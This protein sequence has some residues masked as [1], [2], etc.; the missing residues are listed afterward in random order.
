M[1]HNTRV[2]KPEK[3]IP[4]EKV[5]RALET[6]LTAIKNKQEPHYKNMAA[7][8]NANIDA[9]RFTLLKT[10]FAKLLPTLR[11]SGQNDGPGPITYLAERWGLVRYLPTRDDAAKFLIHVGGRNHAL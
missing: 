11:Q 3:S 5:V 8:V 6:N 7:C 9:N 1:S 10:Q 2:A 4:Q